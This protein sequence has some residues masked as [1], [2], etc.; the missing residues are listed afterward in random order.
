MATTAVQPPATQT[1]PASAKSQ[2]LVGSV[3]GAAFVLAGIVLAGYGVPMLLKNVSLGNTF[4]TAFVRVVAQLAVIGGLAYVGGKL[5]GANPPKGLRGGIGLMIAAAFTFFF[6]VRAVGLNFGDIPAAVV[7]AALAFGLFRLLT[8]PRGID[9]MHALEEQG[10]FHT[11][12]Y[13][14]SQGRKMR[15]YTLIGLLIVGLS[16]VYSI[17]SHD[18]LGSGDLVFRLPFGLPNFTALTDQ[19]FAVPLLLALAVVWLAWRAINIPTFADF[20]IATEAEMNKVSWSS[21]KR[22]IQDTI[23]VLVTTLILTLFLLV[24]DLFWG[25]FL[26]DLLGILPKANPNVKKP[27]VTGLSRPW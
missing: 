1:P 6:V 26:S 19:K 12:S 22:L 7:A 2:L 16:G 5:A 10:W 14:R 25:W 27:D 24:I 8:G 13:K 4:V 3:V 23:V 18:M 15:Q 17:M 11:N 21:R 20:L 9:W